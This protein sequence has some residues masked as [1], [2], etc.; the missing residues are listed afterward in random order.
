MISFFKKK[1]KNCRIRVAIHVISHNTKV[2]TDTSMILNSLLLYLHLHL[3]K[4]RLTEVQNRILTFYSSP[5]LLERFSS[6]FS[7]TVTAIG[8]QKEDYENVCFIKI[9]TFIVCFIA[10]DESDCITD[11]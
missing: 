6:T 3:H 11:T 2:D 7:P 5:L 9:I 1:K 4:P 10:S 8:L